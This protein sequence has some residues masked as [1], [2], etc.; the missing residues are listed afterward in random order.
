MSTTAG[1]TAHPAPHH[2]QSFWLWVMCL[3]GVDYF[4]TL[5]YQPSIAYSNAGLLAPLA[6]VV[7]V[8]VTLFGAY[9]VYAFVARCS[10]E[11]QGSIGMLAGLVSG[12]GGKVLVLTLL[13]FAATD[14][15][16]TKTMSAAD[17][18]KHLIENPH[19]PLPGATAAVRDRQQLLVTL[20]LLVMLGGMFI[21]GFREV[22][23]I[24]V[25]LTAVYLALN[26]VVLGVALSYL[27]AHPDLVTGW[28]A[29]VA[30]GD[31]HLSNPPLANG[32][33]WL[34][35]LAVVLLVFPKLALGLSGFETGVA[36]M[37]L[38]RGDAGDT[39]AAPAGRIRNTRRLL[40][41]AGVVMSGFLLLGSSAGGEHAHPAG[42]LAV[43]RPGHRPGAGVLA[44][45]LT[46]RQGVEK[47]KVSPPAFERALAYLAHGENKEPHKLSAPFFGEASSAPCTTCR[48]WSSSGSPARARWPGC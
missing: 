48:R 4:S 36:V 41:T 2:P 24:A 25:V 13:G 6:S 5:G 23:G 7:L 10:H 18:A 11:G 37:P 19:W 9:P 21:R 33:G 35:T 34:F 20:G 17:A 15:V 16:I 40:L 22:I 27:T 39:P 30:A 12:W 1:P 32:S 38:V 14:F 42:R 43:P 46:G 47:P 28:W 45:G 44:G 31:W 26:A 29:K 3:T 8:L